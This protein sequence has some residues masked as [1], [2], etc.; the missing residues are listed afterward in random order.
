M[1]KRQEIK[2]R[3]RKQKQQRRMLTIGVIVIGAGLISAA[4]IYPGTQT[5]NEFRSREI[6]QDNT[7]GNPDA[8]ITITEYSD[9]KCGH[10]AYFTFDTEH[11]LEDEYINTGKVYFI[12]RSV[13]GM[14]SG[15]QPL[16]AAEAAY[17]A[18]EQNKFWELHDL[19]FANQTTTFSKGTLE[20]WAKTAGAD[21][22]E[23]K[24]CMANNTY[25]DRA[26]QDEIDAKAEGINGTPS[27]II[28][29]VVDGEEVK[30]ILPGN[31]P[32]QAFQDVIE[33]ALAEMGLN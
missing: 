21:V 29:Y 9:Y 30:E 8:P 5:N 10:C 28:T 32:F 7:M 20:K 19:I 23:Y 22:D 16:L 13:G 1:S 33:R 2:N 25:F 17:C 15:A 18:G 27:F 11:L 31:Y 14:L 24:A 6:A 3:R 4:L 26:N 12:S